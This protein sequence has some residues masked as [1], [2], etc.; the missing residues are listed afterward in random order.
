MDSKRTKQKNEF[1]RIICQFESLDLSYHLWSN[2]AKQHDFISDWFNI[3]VKV[4]FSESRAIKVNDAALFSF[5]TYADDKYYKEAPNSY[6][7]FDRSRNQRECYMYVPNKL[8]ERFCFLCN[9]NIKPYFVL[10]CFTGDYKAIEIKSF[11]MRNQIDLDD[12]I[13]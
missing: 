10:R 9:Q 6:G 5:H 11:V 1:Y 8:I 3:N 12:Y 13:K 2:E 7:V 4:I